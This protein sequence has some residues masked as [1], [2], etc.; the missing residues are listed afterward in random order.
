LFNLQNN[1]GT[2]SNKDLLIQKI[3]IYHLP[4]YAF[5]PHASHPSTS[6]F[7]QLVQ[8][9]KQSCRTQNNKV[10]QSCGTQSNKDLLI[11]KKNILYIYIYQVPAYAHLPHASH[12][13]TSAF[14]QLVQP[15]K[16]S[17]RTQNNKVKQSCGTQSNKDLLIK[18]KKKKKVTY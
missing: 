5:L 2:H 7:L 12:P 11:Q 15:S 1:H 3:Y 9:T 8:P 18:K 6:A 14:L 4:A 17:C 16:Q 13:S 10:K